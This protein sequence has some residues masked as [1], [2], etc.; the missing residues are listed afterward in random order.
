MSLRGAKRRG[1][2]F[3][4]FEIASLQHSPLAMTERAK[5]HKVQVGQVIMYNLGMK[6]KNRSA[7]VTGAST[8]IGRAISI[9]LGKEGA[10]VA[11]IARNKVLLEE[12]KILVNKAGGGAE[13]FPTDLS[14]I[15]S[16]NDLIRKI[17]KITKKVDILLNVAGIWHGINEVYADKNLEFFSQKIIMDTFMVG[18]IAPT[19][20]THAFIPLM[21]KGSRIINISGT[22]ENGA[23]GWLPYFVSKRAIEDLTIGLSQELENK[24]IFVNAISP[25]DTATE[26][27][28]KY[29]PQYIKDAI[30]PSEIAKFVIHLCSEETNGVTGKV[31]VLK[32]DQKPFEHFHY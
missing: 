2:L 27:Y 9:A 23:K 13:I 18:T 10:F 4:R 28:Q 26:A 16:I 25:S 24:N 14:Q 20:L 1:N 11:L 31:F 17:K 3:Y 21:P 30:S 7:I 15:D 29:F 8:G 12:T 5:W 6:L 22:F 19:L 32:K